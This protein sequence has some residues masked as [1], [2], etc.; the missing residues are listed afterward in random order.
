MQAIPACTDECIKIQ[1]AQLYQHQ[2]KLCVPHN[3]PCLIILLTSSCRD[4]RFT[5][6][7]ACV[8]L[9]HTFITCCSL[10]GCMLASL[11]SNPIPPSYLGAVSQLSFTPTWETMPVRGLAPRHKCSQN[12]II[13]PQWHHVV[14]LLSR[15]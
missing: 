14:G 8:S 1:Y 2:C 3:L 15:V 7:L 5:H 13:H 9:S 12:Y 6:Q 11:S 4:S 10:A